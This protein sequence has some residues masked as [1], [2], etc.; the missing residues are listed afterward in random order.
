MGDIHHP[1]IVRISDR[2]TFL[3]IERGTLHASRH[4]LEW[5]RETGTV[6]IPAGL[7]T[8]VFIEPGVAVTHAAVKLCADHGTLLLWTGEA[9]VHLYSAGLPGGAAGERL[10]AQ[11]ALRLDAR[12]RVETAR[13]F[14]TR[15][16]GAIQ[17]PA[18]DIE[19]LR[20]IEGARVKTW[21]AEIAAQT[22]VPWQGRE[23]APGPLR[24]ALGYATA[25]LYGVCEAVIL[26]AGYSPAIGFIHTGDR[27]SLVFDLADTVK[28][29]TVV[30]A[31]FRVYA[32]GVEDVRSRVRR[33]CRDLFRAENTIATLFDNLLYAMGESA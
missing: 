7:A 2:I 6:A 13:R 28:F 32:D 24:D 25:A 12:G 1:G 16:F 33:R 17:P 23:V 9:G 29:R 15:M 14:Y 22:G 11:A 26:A 3:V 8:T 20:G 18:H 5:S 21:Y 31:A 10:L 27:R 19:K 4:S 30:P